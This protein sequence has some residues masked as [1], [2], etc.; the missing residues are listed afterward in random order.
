MLVNNPGK[1]VSWKL[2]Y[3]IIKEQKM[4]YDNLIEYSINNQNLQC[5]AFIN[6]PAQQ[7][8]DIPSFRWSIIGAD[9]APDTLIMTIPLTKEDVTLFLASEPVLHPQKAPWD[10][11][12]ALHKSHN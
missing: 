12:P 5:I 8:T 3:K 10:G 1:A 9:N 2:R 7:L 6:L 4:Y 11:W